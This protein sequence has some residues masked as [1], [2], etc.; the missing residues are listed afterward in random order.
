M[1]LAPQTVGP[2]FILY[3]VLWRTLYFHI[4]DQIQI[5]AI[6]DSRWLGRWRR[7]RSLPFLDCLLTCIVVLNCL[8]T[9]S[10]SGMVDCLLLLWWQECH[11][12]ITKVKIKGFNFQ[13][14]L[15]S[16]PDHFSGLLGPTV[17]GPDQEFAVYRYTWQCFGVIFGIRQC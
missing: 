12:L 2:L 13:A 1:Q 7:G 17:S 15:G 10:I 14:D 5:Q 6:G 8:T 4:M 3:S 9:D 16:G 11:Q